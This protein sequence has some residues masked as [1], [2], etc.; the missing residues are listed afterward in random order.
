VASTTTPSALQDKFLAMERSMN[1]RLFER[2]TE[3]RT[4]ILALIGRLHWFALGTPGTAKSYTIRLMRDHIAG[5]PENGYKELLLTR[6]TTPEEA[7]GPFNIPAM[8]EGRY[9]RVTKGYFPEAALWFWDEIFKCGASMLNSALAALNERVYHSGGKAIPLVLSSMFCASNELP[10]NEAELAALYD[11]LHFRHVIEPVKED[12][13]FRRVLHSETLGPVSPVVTWDEVMQAQTEVEHTKIGDEVYDGLVE[14]RQSLKAEGI[15]PTDRRF[16]ASLQV[17][18]AQAWLNGHDMAKKRDMQPLA[19]FFWDSPDQRKAVVKCVADLC[20]KI[21]RKLIDLQEQIENLADEVR[22]VVS[23]DP[24]KENRLRTK[25]TM[26][27]NAKLD[28]AQEELKQLAADAAAADESDN[29]L[30]D[31]TKRRLEHIY[32]DLYENVLGM[33]RGYTVDI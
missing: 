12:S 9:E 26:D 6:F 19:H 1:D 24:K 25:A 23:M 2:N 15:M 33:P 17:V 3:I 13:N 11:R 31:Q 18:R 10:E 29:P 7:F 20:S 14:L 32:N 16:V 5:L 22:G 28:E 30:L 8:Q 4:A 21:D 27:M